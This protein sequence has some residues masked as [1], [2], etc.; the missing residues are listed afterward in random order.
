MICNVHRYEWNHDHEGIYVFNL[1]FPGIM[2]QT[3]TMRLNHMWVVQ[4]AQV[5]MS[6]VVGLEIAA[7]TDAKPTEGGCT[8]RPDLRVDGNDAWKLWI[9]QIL[10]GST[11]FA[12]IVWN[13]P[14]KNWRNPASSRDSTCQSLGLILSCN[15]VLMVD[16]KIHPE[17]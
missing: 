9:E 4:N 3:Y 8:V 11:G 2:H 15:K 5:S 14:K 10:W 12:I 13:N 16:P 6:R 7:L 17:N 1:T